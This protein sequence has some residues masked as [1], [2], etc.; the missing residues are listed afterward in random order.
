MTGRKVEYLSIPYKSIA[1]FSVETA[2]NFDLDAEMKIWLSG[3]ST[4]VEK[5][6]K[7]GSK[8]I[9]G[10]QESVGRTHNLAQEFHQPQPLVLLHRCVILAHQL[11]HLFTEMSLPL[12]ILQ[13]GLLSGVGF[14]IPQII[15]EQEIEVDDV[16]MR[17]ARLDTH[18]R[19][20]LGEG[21]RRY[22]IHAL[23][24]RWCEA[25]ANMRRHQSVFI[26]RLVALPCH[27]AHID[28]APVGDV[29]MTA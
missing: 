11:H 15:L 26:E 1:S 25:P 24:L 20:V 18:H 23:Q 4:P 27:A 29:H 13:R 21:K 19:T 3:R 10:V 16:R 12:C 5:K 9:V 22:Q 7:R 17:L 2:G 6:F 8:V 14:R 28:I